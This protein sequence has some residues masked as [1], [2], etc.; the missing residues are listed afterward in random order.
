MAL[1]AIGFL[2]IKENFYLY[3]IS[4]IVYISIVSNSNIALFV[5]SLIDI[6]K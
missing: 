6:D 1:E 4:D 2:C 5:Y 3:H